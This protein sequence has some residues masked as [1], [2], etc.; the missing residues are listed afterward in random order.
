MCISPLGKRMEAPSGPSDM[1]IPFSANIRATVISFSLCVSPYTAKYAPFGCR[2]RSTLNPPISR[3]SA[4]L[5]LRLMRF[6]FTFIDALTR[7]L[8]TPLYNWSSAIVQ[9][10]VNATGNL[11]CV[12]SCLASVS[13]ELPCII[14]VTD[15][16]QPVPSKTFVVRPVPFVLPTLRTFNV[17]NIT[18]TDCINPVHSGK[19]RVGRVDWITQLKLKPAPLCKYIL[20]AFCPSPCHNL[21]RY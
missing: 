5:W 9:P 12:C 2:L 18:G 3:L 8:S 4:S 6:S 19:C 21:I 20:H 17:P 1:E 10:H 7:I 15:C 14:R 11:N 13:C 16:K